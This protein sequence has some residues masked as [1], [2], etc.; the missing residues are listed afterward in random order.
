MNNRMS[1]VFQK[2]ILYLLLSIGLLCFS[3]WQ[4]YDVIQIFEQQNTR[5][6]QGV[7]C[8]FTEPVFDHIFTFYTSTPVYLDYIK[9]YASIISAFV[10]DWQGLE[11][12]ALLR[13]SHAAFV[14]SILL[15]YLWGIVKKEP[16]MG[17]LGAYAFSVNPILVFASLRWDVFILAIPLI[18]L[19]ILLVSFT[20]GFTAILPTILFCTLVWCAAF[21]SSRETDNFLLLLSIGSVACGHWLQVLWQGRAGAR[22]IS[23]IKSS[24]MAISAGVIILFLISQYTYFTSP[25]G[26]YYY[27]REAEISSAET[28]DPAAWIHRT[29]YWGHLYWRG[30]GPVWASIFL[31]SLGW[32]VI[33]QKL[34][35]AISV[36]L[37]LPFLLLSLLSKKNFYYL[38]GVWG[39]IPLVIALAIYQLPRW[40]RWIGLI[41]LIWFGQNHMD[42]RRQGTLDLASDQKYGGIFQTSDQGLS[43]QP[44]QSRVEEEIAMILKK[45]LPV[46]PCE[47]ARWIANYAPLQD[48]EIEIRLKQQFP[49]TTL[50]RFPRMNRLSEIS[51]FLIQ[52]K[53]LSASYRENL[54]DQKFEAWGQVSIGRENQIEIWGKSVMLKRNIKRPV[55]E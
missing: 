33:S 46:F 42:S 25:E 22:R 7:C 39:L 37:L 27:F 53:D 8:G 35:W 51:A 1:P 26:A 54:P 31:I 18:L 9:G 13:I 44:R 52:T 34:D 48:Q 6:A 28:I 23:R 19:A 47:E 17:A 5:Y 29:A 11:E 21:W 50:K 14:L 30:I 16:L 55:E 38:F 24:W 15:C 32:G 41:A 20:R 12:K 40:W 4:Y 3:I 49:C 10:F 2:K 45:N 43:F 36:A